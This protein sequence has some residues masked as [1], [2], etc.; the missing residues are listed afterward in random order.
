MRL[1]AQT[2]PTDSCVSTLV[3][4]GHDAN[5]PAV[6]RRIAAF[7]HAGVAVRPFT[8]RRGAARAAIKGNVDLG[9]TSARRRSRAKTSN[10]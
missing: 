7:G 1:A 5:D 4:F 10:R 3:F 9:E 8:M 2:G 6:Q